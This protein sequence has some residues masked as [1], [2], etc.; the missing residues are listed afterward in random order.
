MVS[1]VLAVIPLSSIDLFKYQTLAQLLDIAPKARPKI[2][3]DILGLGLGAEHSPV[4]SRFCILL[5][6]Y[7]QTSCLLSSSPKNKVFG[8]SRIS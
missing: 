3:Y 8:Y 5:F 1:M 4:L 2:T 7:R 6:C